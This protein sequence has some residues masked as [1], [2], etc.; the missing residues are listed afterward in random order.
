MPHFCFYHIL[1]SSGITEQAHRAL[2]HGIYSL[3]SH[4][5]GQLSRASLFQAFSFWGQHKKMWK[6]KQRGLSRAKEGSLLSPP[7]P[8][9]FF[10]AAPTLCRIPNFK[11]LGQARAESAA[12]SIYKHLP[13]DSQSSTLAQRSIAP[14][15]KSRRNHRFYVRTSSTVFVLASISGRRVMNGLWKFLTAPKIL[16]LL[17]LLAKFKWVL[18]CSFSPNFCSCSHTR[19]LVSIARN[20]VNPSLG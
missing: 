10:P 9:Y 20:F 2:Q 13:E 6:E 12:S 5:P 18:A 15:H 1:T 14:L 4:Y 16:P 3:N 17:D 11:R 19:F 8:P 7:L